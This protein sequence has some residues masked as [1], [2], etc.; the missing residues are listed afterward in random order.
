VALFLSEPN[1]KRSPLA[2]RAVE[3]APK[4]SASITARPTRNTVALPTHMTLL[5]ALLSI[6]LT[7]FRTYR[8]WDQGRTP[9]LRNG[10]V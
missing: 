7:P 3:A 2:P 4:T 8:G 6:L 5:A 9:R 10:T 1:L